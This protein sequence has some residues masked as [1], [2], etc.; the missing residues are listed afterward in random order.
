MSNSQSWSPWHLEDF[1]ANATDAASNYAQKLIEIESLK[2]ELQKERANFQSSCESLIVDELKKAYEEGFAK[3][4]SEGESQGYLNGQQKAEEEAA[5]KQDQFVE[6]IENLFS[7]FN[8]L[9]DNT[10]NLLPE[11]MLIISLA[12]AKSLIGN[13]IDELQGELSEKIMDE[14]EKLPL[15][16]RQLTLRINPN[17][18]TFIQGSITQLFAQNNWKMIKDDS[19]VKSGFIIETD[20]Q[21]IDAT[22]ES[23]WQEIIKLSEGIFLHDK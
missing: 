5:I 19:L 20:T 4:L 14:L 18:W 10:N 17:D 6:K 1:N 16:P 3:G 9:I 8:K 7:Q 2:E 12:A 22:L 11:K 15:A 21:E 13:K 23:K